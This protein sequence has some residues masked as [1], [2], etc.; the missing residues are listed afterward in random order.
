MA[1]NL[2]GFQLQAPV[3]ESLASLFGLAAA[4]GGWYR[5]R[6]DRRA[7]ASLGDTTLR[8]MG[9]VRGDVEREHLK[10]FWQ[11]VD[12]DALEAVRRGR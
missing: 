7:L 10:P 4:A 2:S 5:N 3:S 6:Q 1:S 12:Y 9:L 11:A 8:D